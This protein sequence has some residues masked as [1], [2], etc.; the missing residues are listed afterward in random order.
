MFT[1]LHFTLMFTSLHWQTARPDSRSCSRCGRSP[2]SGSLPSCG[3]A[4][5]AREAD[6]FATCGRSPPSVSF[7]ARS[8]SPVNAAALGAATVDG[9]AGAIAANPSEAASPAKRKRLFR[10]SGVIGCADAI[11]ARS[12]N[13]CASRIVRHGLGQPPGCVQVHSTRSLPTS[14]GNSPSTRAL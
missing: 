1:S 14:N 13:S 6:P 7:A 4:R 2:P 10:C 5:G 3:A 8:R 11:G 12:V 9:S